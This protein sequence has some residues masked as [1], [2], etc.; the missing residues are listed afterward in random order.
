MLVPGGIELQKCCSKHEFYNSPV[1]LWAVG[2]IMVELYTLKPLFQGSSETDQMMKIFNV[3]G[4]P[5]STNWPDGVRLLNKLNIRIPLQAPISIQGLVPNASS[6][7]VDL[8]TRLLRLDPAKRINAAQALI[9]PFFQG[10]MQNIHSLLIIPE[11]EK[12]KSNRSSS[13][14]IVKR[15]HRSNSTQ[16]PI[17]PEW[18][19]GTNSNLC[20]EPNFDDIFENLEDCW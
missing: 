8:I 20:Q 12:K 16:S 13:L 1:D 6:N 3:V 2:A 9:H 19:K 4:T 7:A 5:S 14:D 17:K 11:K 15:V 10:E 18:Q